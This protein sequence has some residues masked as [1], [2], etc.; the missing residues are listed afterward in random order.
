MFAVFCVCVRDFRNYASALDI[1]IDKKF[2]KT[3]S[4]KDDPVSPSHELNSAQR[5]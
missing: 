1:F 5:Y 4:F 3:S 2:I